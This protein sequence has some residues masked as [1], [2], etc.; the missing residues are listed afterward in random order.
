VTESEAMSMHMVMATSSPPIKYLSPP[1]LAFVEAFVKHRDEF[2][3][4]AMFTIDAGANIHLL[5]LRSAREA[6]LQFAQGWE[7]RMFT[8]HNGVRTHWFQCILLSGKRYSGKSTLAA[9]LS[10]QDSVQVCSISTCIKRSYWESAETG[11]E[12]DYFVN[13]REEK[14][15]HR[16]AMVEFMQ[17]KVEEAGD[18]HWLWKLWGSVSAY[19]RILVVDDAR[20]ESDLSF[21]KTC[22]KCVSVRIECSDA[23]R[24]RRG[25]SKSEV[26]DMLSE[27]G[28]DGSEFDVVVQEG[29]AYPSLS[30][31]LNRE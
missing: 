10:A 16:R 7:K 14:E 5:W 6:V 29:E 1:S 9:S 22:T 18:R 26:D 28:L 21:F 2:S 31:L 12:W 11:V 23:T 19:P 25:W 30:H 20:R 13:S 8:L 15:K 3:L 24:S 27:K 17:R 4:R